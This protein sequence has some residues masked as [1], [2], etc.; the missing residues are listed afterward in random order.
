MEIGGFQKFSVLDYPEKTC[1]IIF[2]QGCN[3]NCPYCHNQA[4]I[5]V[6]KGEIKE[7]DIF[8][9]LK[10]RKGRLDGVV[11]TGGEPTIQKDLIPF[12]TKIKKEGFLVKLDTNGSNPNVVKEIID[13]Q[14]VDFI[15]MD[16]K[17][18]YERYNEMTQTKVDI[19]KIKKS[20]TLIENS[21]IDFL[22]RTTLYKLNDIDILEI[23]KY[24]KKESKYITQKYKKTVGQE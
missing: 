15:A 2:T 4:L 8:A 10:K 3:F 22:F 7:K 24:L 18:P 9:F 14:L 20:I 6:K 19:E 21:K 13:K 11:I 17:S 5:P 16:I 12:I 1:A 23:R